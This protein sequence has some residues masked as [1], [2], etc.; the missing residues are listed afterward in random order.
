MVEFLRSGQYFEAI[1]IA[2]KL[3]RD[4]EN[5]EYAPFRPH[6]CSTSCLYKQEAEAEDVL[7]RIVKSTS[8]LELNKIVHGKTGKTI[9]FSREI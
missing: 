6:S 2:E 9:H 8:K 4:E 7:I 1:E 3:Q 5:S